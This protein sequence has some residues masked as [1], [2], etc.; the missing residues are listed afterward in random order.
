MELSYHLQPPHKLSAPAL[1]ALQ[2]VGRTQQGGSQHKSGA[3]GK[4]GKEKMGKSKEVRESKENHHGTRV[5]SE[6]TCS[7]ELGS[8]EGKINCGWTGSLKGK[9]PVRTQPKR[10]YS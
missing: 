3:E 2:P 4:K 5:F 1:E 10:L 7:Q 9:Q 6:F 8:S